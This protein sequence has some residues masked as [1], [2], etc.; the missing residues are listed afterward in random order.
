MTSETVKDKNVIT[1]TDKEITKELKR[2]RENEDIR[3]EE[4]YR[5]YG[6]YPKEVGFTISVNK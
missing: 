2:L 3:R 4:H 5:K 6:E 1:N